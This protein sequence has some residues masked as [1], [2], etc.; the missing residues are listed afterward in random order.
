MKLIADS[1]STKTD[2]CLIDGRNV[3]SRFCGQGI[4]PSLQDRTV[5]EKILSED[6]KKAVLF[7]DT[8]QEIC[9]YGAGCREEAMPLMR[10]ILSKKFKKAGFIEVNGDLL[11]A[12]RALF[13]DKEGIACILGTGSNSCFYDGTKVVSNVPPL[14]FILGD[15]GSGAVLGKI[16]INAMFKG[17]LSETLRDEF[18]DEMGLSLSDIISKVYREPAPNRFLAS[19]STFIH[20]HLDD[21]DLRTLVVGNFINFF[22]RNVNLYNRKDV[23]VGAIGGMAYNYKSLFIEV[24]ESEG[25]MVGKVLQSPMDGLVER[26]RKE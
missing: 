18:C 17:V 20:K 14:G 23:V 4:N 10:D 21:M 26:E 24:A 2:W 5:I 11:A 6:L 8:V 16:F 9:F 1:G 12:A 22:R 3:V 25:Y 13:D 19:T 15:E 7:A